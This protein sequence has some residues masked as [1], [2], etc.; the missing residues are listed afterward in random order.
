MRTSVLTLVQ[1]RQGD[2]NIGR[3]G[4]CRFQSLFDPC[5]LFNSSVISLRRTRKRP[6]FI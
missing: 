1:C 2:K 5:V 3:A 4:R 6:L